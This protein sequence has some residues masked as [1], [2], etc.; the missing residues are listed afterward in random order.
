VSLDIG[1]W[2][3]AL[4]ALYGQYGYAL[5]FLGA[6]GEN[7][8]FAGLVLPGGTLALLGAMYARSGDLAL[9]WVIL[10]AWIGTVI[11][12]HVDFLIGRYAL[13]WVVNGV[14]TS[15]MG[16]RWRVAGRVRLARSLLNRHGGK[17]I[18]ISHMAGHIRSFV[19]MSAG[20]TR[21]RYRR[22]LMFELVAALLWN[23][24]FVMA[25]YLIGGERERLQLFIERSGWVVLVA[26]VV[27]YVIW[28][29]AR[30]RWKR[31]KP[32]RHTRKPGGRPDVAAAPLL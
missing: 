9:G 13:S 31:G 10:L 15:R 16:K 12:Y 7:T 24:L 5:V 2:L 29:F 3:D 22:F 30:R 20:A 26:V 11:G 17:A 28:R 14:S 23:T 4:E 18:L 25:G 32:A 27:G 19:A 6:L 1:A 21:M 8:A